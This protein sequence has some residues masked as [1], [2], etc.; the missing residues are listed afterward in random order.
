ML[1][2]AIFIK[3]DQIVKKE[4]GEVDYVKV[5]VVDKPEVMP[6]GILH[7]VDAK[8][9]MNVQVNLFGPLFTVDNAKD[10]G[11]DWISHFNKDSLQIMKNAVWFNMYKDVKPYDRFQFQRLGYFT[12]SDETK[13]GKI[14]I[15]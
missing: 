5:H 6:K 14:V 2:Y 3:I 15:Y 12:V 4:N 13:D 11:A 8:S 10:F 9:S 1:R 7:W